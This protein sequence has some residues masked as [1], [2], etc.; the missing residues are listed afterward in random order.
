MS[1]LGAVTTGPTRSGLRMIV[2]ALEKMGKTTI[3][4][5]APASLLIPLEVGYAGIVTAKTPMLQTLDEFMQLLTEI[6]ALAQRGQFPYRTIVIDSATALE[7]QIHEY[8]L[9]QDPLYSPTAKKTISME[10]AHGGYGKAYS[11]ANTMTSQV[12]GLLDQLAVHAGI[13]IIV[14]CH[15]FA[16]KL[17][18]PTTGEYESWDLLLHS[19][20]NQKTYGKREMLT[21]WADIVGFLYEPIFLSKADGATMTRATSQNK[22]RMLGLSRV[23]SYVAGNRFGV[24]GE[25]QIPPPPNNGWNAFAHA[26]YNASGI[27]VFTR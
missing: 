9:R 3:A 21:Q 24:M 25:I 27:D 5:Q 14:T 11:L 12:L 20:K 19:P 17:M 8:V 1:I 23:P 4:T 10:S 18:D 26:L 6:T 22:G 7:R 15:V 16:S 13:N 2:A